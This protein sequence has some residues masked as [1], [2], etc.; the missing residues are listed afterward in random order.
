[1]VDSLNMT[2]KN[3]ALVAGF[4]QA[5]SAGLGFVSGGRDGWEGGG[6]EGKRIQFGIT[7][8][9][10]TTV[11]ID[12]IGPVFCGLISAALM[13]VGYLIMW[14]QITAR[15]P[16]QFIGMLMSYFIVGVGS[17]IVTNVQSSFCF[18]LTDS[19]THPPPIGHDICHVEQC[20]QFQSNVARSHCGF[21]GIEFGFGFVGVHGHFP[22]GVFR[23]V[24]HGQLCALHGD[25][26]WLFESLGCL[27]CFISARSKQVCQLEEEAHVLEARQEDAVIDGY[28]LG[29]AGHS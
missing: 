12:A 14:L 6:K 24:V 9:T 7:F 3:S 28:S 20:A 17:Q 18:V 21:D 15:L 4:G 11:L 16:Y 8:H 26:E 25:C 1:M 19:L 29:V 5:G 2:Q 13:F 10:N 27:L 22:L 23:R